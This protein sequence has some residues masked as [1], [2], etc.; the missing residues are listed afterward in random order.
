MKKYKKIIISAALIALI[1]LV[2]GVSI[3]SS[4]QKAKGNTLPMPLGFGIAVT[5]TG[6]MEPN[7]PKG[8]LIFLIK[9]KSYEV[10]D[11]VA[12]LKDGEDVH[13]VHRIVEIDGNTV[14][15]CGDANEGSNDAPIDMGRIKG[16]VLF[17]IPKI[18]F[19]ILKFGKV[20]SHPVVLTILLLVF[21]AAIIF[22][23]IVPEK[24]DD[25]QT[26]DEIKAEIEKLKQDKKDED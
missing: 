4:V 16:K 25:S 24:R 21:A 2:A 18:G 26:I 5:E 6:S 9:S 10:G 22:T 17:N 14:T 1:L 13:T 12:F 15:T 11:I 3:Y 20:I 19:P 8:S 23:F 7:M